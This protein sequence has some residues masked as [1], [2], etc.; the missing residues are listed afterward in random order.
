MSKKQ[1][2]ALV[3]L[4]I[5]IFGCRFVPWPPQIPPDVLRTFDQSFMERMDSPFFIGI[6]ILFLLLMI[7]GVVGM[8][9]FGNLHHISSSQHPF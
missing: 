4:W 9:R 3:G 5:V 7:I 6:A 8:L 2:R 1:F